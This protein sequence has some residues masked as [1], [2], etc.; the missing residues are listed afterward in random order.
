MAASAGL[1][2]VNRSDAVPIQHIYDG[3]WNYFVGGGVAVFDC[4]NDQRPEIF[5]A[6]GENPAR[7]FVNSSR[8]DGDIQFAIGD[9]PEI[10]AVTGVYPI[11]IDSDGLLDLVILRH[12]ENVIYRG[13]KNCAFV[14]A[15]SEWG[16]DGGNEWTT[17][18]TATFEPQ[19]D[20]PT[21]V[22]GNYVDETNPKG[23]FEA[24]DKN[25]LIRPNGSA[26][27]E[28]T[29]LEPGYCALSM[30]ISDW[31][32]NGEPD[33]RISND[34][35]YYV[36]NGQEQMWHLSPL[37]LYSANDGWPDLRLWGMGIASRD[38]TGDGL[39]EVVLTSMGDQHLQINQGNGV[40]T[41]APYAI[42]TYSTTPYIGDDGRPSTGWQA[43]FGD[44]NNDGLDDLFI[45]KGNVDQMPSNAIHDPNNLLI[46]NVDGTFTEM[47]DITGLGTTERARGAALVDLNSDGLLDVVVVNRRAPL[48]VWQNTTQTD[49][50][51]VAI[52][53]NQSGPNGRAIGAFVELKLPNGRVL[54]QENTI[55]G[56]HASGTAAPLHFGLG[57][58]DAIAIRVI[59]PD[60]GVSNW[61]QIRTNQ[62][63]TITRDLNKSLIVTGG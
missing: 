58:V 43:S 16:F 5:S 2:F 48:E 61:T 26:F 30:L 7:L 1:S 45:A 41:S 40:M 37:Q 10:K 63:T 4:N 11:D 23:P 21:L 36:R 13:Q 55:G 28:R 18:F 32:R 29:P 62:I 60:G 56:G 50:N 44:L 34:R 9:F 17:S 49:G 19:N 24:C 38:I 47:G 54:T 57:P 14:P 35:Q 6:G 39:P 59:W 42:G 33:L 15:P 22:F 31:K 3:G 8:D 20:W 27:A 53:L 12:G 25:Y 52:D 46:Q 51:W